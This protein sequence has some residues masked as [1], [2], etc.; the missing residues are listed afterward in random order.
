ML[1]VLLLVLALVLVLQAHA[2]VHPVSASNSYTTAGLPRDDVKDPTWDY[3]DLSTWPE[4]CRKGSRQ[5]PISFSELAPNEVVYRKDL[6]PLEFSEGCAFTAEKVSLKIENDVN[7]ISVRLISLDDPYNEAPSPCTMRDPTNPDSPLFHFVSMHLHSPAEHVFPR[8]M[9]NAELHILFVNTKGSNKA[10]RMVVAVQLVASNKL[11]TTSVR[12]LRHIL[13]EGSL[14]PKHAITTCTLTEDIAIPKLLPRR[15]SY[16]AYDGSLTTP[17]CTEGVRFIVM[18]SPQIISRLALGRL[19]EAFNKSRQGNFYGNRRPTQ[20]LN[21]RA[22]YRF[23]DVK[24]NKT[25]KSKGDMDDYYQSDHHSEDVWGNDEVVKNHSVI[26]ETKPTQ[27]LNISQ[28]NATHISWGHAGGWPRPFKLREAF[29]FTCAAAVLL[30]VTILL[31]RRWSGA[32]SLRESGIEEEP[33][34]HVSGGYGTAEY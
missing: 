34:A 13:V 7:T 8:T 32:T 11:N 31:Y 27:S 26:T 6:G 12:A 17:P 19:V 2:F 15:G 21:G 20:P 24:H 9:P 14:P 10:Q 30:I 3:T 28:T 5:S 4:T 29:V 33:L 25:V 18:T 23:V 16:L 22:V 1:R